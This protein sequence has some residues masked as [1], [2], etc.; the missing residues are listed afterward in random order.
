MDNPSNFDLKLDSLKKS[1]T[2]KWLMQQSLDVA[3]LDYSTTKGNGNEPQ[4]FS[5]R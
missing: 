5:R 3:A 4:V 1:A 2:D